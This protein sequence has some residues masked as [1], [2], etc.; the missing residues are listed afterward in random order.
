MN[1]VVS[2]NVFEI[3]K[4]NLKESDK[5]L[6]SIPQ[7][8]R[9]SVWKPHQIELLWDSLFRN[10]PIG[11]LIVLSQDISQDA[12]KGEIIDGQQRV[13]AIISAFSEV[14]DKSDCVVWIDLNAETLKDRKYAIRVTSR[15]HPWGYKLDGS[16]YEAEIRN[17]SIRK[18]GETPGSQKSSWNILNFGP[19]GEN[20]LPVPLEFFLTSE[21]SD[22]IKEKCKKLSETAP[23]WG[24]RYLAKVQT[25]DEEKFKTILSAVSILKDTGPNQYS[26]P[27]III[28]TR[29]DLDLLFSRIGK[30][31]T[32]ITDKELAYALMKS[33]WNQQGFGATNAKLCKGIVSEEDF[34]Q[35]IFRLFFSQKSIHGAI[36]PE[37][38]RNL[39]EKP[40]EISNQILDAYQNDG[41]G[42]KN[43]IDCVNA[44]LL[45][46]YEG[47]EKYH[48]LIA[49][50]IAIRKPSLYILLLR[51]AILKEKNMLELSPEYV[52]ALAFF[53]YTCLNKDKAIDFLYSKIMWNHG[54]ITQ[55]F[56]TEVL[57]D[58]ISYSCEWA[59]PIVDSFKNFPGVSG[60][61][62]D[63]QWSMERYTGFPGGHLFERFFSYGTPESAFLLKLAERKYFN[64]QYPDYNP[65]RKDLWVDQNR[66]WDHDHI[67][68]Q[69]W[70][71]DDRVC[72]SWINCIGNIADIPFELNRAKQDKPE[73]DHYQKYGDE[74]LFNPSCGFCNINDNLPSSEE[75][76]NSLFR[77]ARDRFLKIVEPFMKIIGHL[78]ILNSLSNNQVLRKQLLCKVKEKYPECKVYYLLKGIEHEFESNDVFGWQQSWVT[79]SYDYGDKE[80]V[81]ALALAIEDDKKFEVQCGLR[82]RPE[83][84]REQ[85]QNHD[86]WADGKLKR[87]KVYYTED[88]NYLSYQGWSPEEEFEK[89]LIASSYKLSRE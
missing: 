75:Q 48:P 60:D 45:T 71:G 44:W 54:P 88:G 9:G 53:L 78:Q 21:G 13:S 10:F 66:P 63:P 70:A 35:L 40:S 81:A 14:S 39:K 65:T 18:A 69:K 22:A 19:A 1:R 74:L 30:Q 56:I 83:L 36:T 87:A 51:L 67:I 24:E 6:L 8:Q 16:V 15:A 7:L 59:L 58:C 26:I 47:K 77:F 32:Q 41:N 4:C 27:A 82:K 50:E 5:S 84:Y 34:A 11:T 49:T 28:D 73:W 17:G 64:K 38:I 86:W 76:R 79:L 43:L 12:P 31:G 42:L 20:V 25:L 62:L 29:E 37:Q 46:C 61:V 72:F 85:M 55:Q 2:Y 23:K 52:Q 68:P 80:R 33:Y 89:L 3:G 57:Q